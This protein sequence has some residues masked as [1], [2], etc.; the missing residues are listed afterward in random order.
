[1]TSV[2]TISIVA[3]GVLTIISTIKYLAEDKSIFSTIFLNLIL[4][5]MAYVLINLI[6]FEIKLNVISG[7]SIIVLGAPGVLLMAILKIIFSIF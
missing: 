4:G 3:V 6:G 2:I 7:A 5:I 1:M